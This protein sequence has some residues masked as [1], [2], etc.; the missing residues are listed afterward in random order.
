M[1][2]SIRVANRLTDAMEPVYVLHGHEVHVRA[3][4]GLAAGRAGIDTAGDVL[5]KADV[6]MYSA[7]ARGKARVVVF[8]PSMHEAVMTRAQLSADLQHA[9]ARREFILQYQPIVDLATCQIVGIE[10]LVRW[11]HPS[12]GR[13]EPDDF[14]RAAE[15]AGTIIEIGRWVLGEACHQIRALHDLVPPEFK[16]SVNVSVRQL[17]QP[18]FVAEVLATIRDAGVDP[19]RIELEMTE[20]VMLKDVPSTRDKLR[21]LRDAGVG[22]SVDDFGTGY[23][24]LSYVQQLPITTLKIARDFVGVTDTDPESWELAGAII[25]LG[26]AL[27]LSVIAE[28]VE[29]R[30]QVDQLRVLGC[31]YAQG[32]Y[33]AR[34]LDSNAIESL[35]ASGGILVEPP[36]SGN[37]SPAPDPAEP[38]SAA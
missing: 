25:A 18:D 20:T 3:S 34:P 30:S 8:E 14:I 2:T 9:I 36:R 35:L 1:K 5:R 38:A 7:K 17:A 6:A 22:I 33:F 27:R 15:E 31:A 21:E 26:R 10:A 24:S 29:L 32:F 28:G 16:M 23:S 13:I 4:I 37:V 19:S 12:R 11:D